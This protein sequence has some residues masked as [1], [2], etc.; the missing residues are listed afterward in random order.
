[1]A[2]YLSA[3]CKGYLLDSL[4]GRAATNLNYT[5]PA[6]I[7]PYAGAQQ[8]DPTVTLTGTLP[9]GTGVLGFNLGTMGAPS[10]G[11]SSIASPK[12]A[13]ATATVA[14]IAFARIYGAL[15]VGIMD[16]TA[17]LT[18]GGG[19]VILN[20]LSTTVGVNFTLSAF[21]FK[22]PQI[23]GTVMLN[24]ALVN[25]IASA[26]CITSAA[27]GLCTSSV[28][29]V[30]SGTPPASADVA[31]T[32]TLLVSFTNGATSPWAVASGPS[33]ALTAPLASSAA[34]ATGTA[35]Y[36]RIVKG[37][38]VLQGTVGTSAADFILD[39]VAI[40]SGNTINLT[41]ATLSL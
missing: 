37:T 13:S 23:N 40:T 9:L 11:V 2:T 22:M 3:A 35:T 21:S 26:M 6:Y 20:T 34:A 33:S 1:M 31:A 19:G 4:T 25:A 36:A 41:E 32:G 18:G 5:A 30:Y 39:T 16:T 10:V 24:I 17:S 8:T 7:T 38:Y 28:T 15:G 29:N 27:V 14:S 12:T